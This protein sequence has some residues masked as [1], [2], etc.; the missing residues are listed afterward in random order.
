MDNNTYGQSLIFIQLEGCGACDYF[1]K[2]FWNNSYILKFLH[3]KNIKPIRFMLSTK[4]KKII[5]KRITSFFEKGMMFPTF[6][7]TKNYEDFINNVNNNIHVYGY[8][9]NTNGLL[10]PDLNVAPQYDVIT[11]WV[12]KVINEPFPL[13]TPKTLNK[14]TIVVELNKSYNDIYRE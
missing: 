1:Y 5:P 3:N 8:K 13:Y 14:R 11:K 10:T 12:E 6:I 9:L 7:Y 2:K 4:D